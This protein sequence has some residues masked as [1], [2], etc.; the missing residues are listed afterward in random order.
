MGVKWNAEK[1]KHNYA[2]IRGGG[3]RNSPAYLV[4][5]NYVQHH[6]STGS[7][8]RVRFVFRTDGQHIRCVGFSLSAFDVVEYFVW[9]NDQ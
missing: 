5:I 1:T 8:F 7:I 6:L 4:K 2:V 3:D 9:N